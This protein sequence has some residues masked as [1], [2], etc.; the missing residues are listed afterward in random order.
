MKPIKFKKVIEDQV[1]Q[2]GRK[3]Y[4]VDWKDSHARTISLRPYES[5]EELS[6]EEFDKRN[7]LLVELK[8]EFGKE[9]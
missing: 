1:V 8:D 2:K 6:A 7:Y 3:L 4:L 9:K 5:G